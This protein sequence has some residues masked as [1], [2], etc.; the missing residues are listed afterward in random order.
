MKTR[1]EEN[2]LA[3]TIGL[4]VHLAVGD[5]VASLGDLALLVVRVGGG[6]GENLCVGEG[7]RNFSES[8]KAK[9]RRK[10]NLRRRC[11]PE[12]ACPPQQTNGERDAM[13]VSCSTKGKGTPRVY[14]A[15]AQHVE[16]LAVVRLTLWREEREKGSLAKRKTQEHACRRRNTQCGLPAA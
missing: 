1:K 10:A 6:A 3:Y 15:V 12:R 9:G 13:N 8:D 14:L 5:I 2:T 7:K 4:L 11:G 16:H